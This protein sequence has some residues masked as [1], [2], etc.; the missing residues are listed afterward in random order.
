M[1]T[2]FYTGLL[3]ALA[4]MATSLSANASTEV[5]TIR[6]EDHVFT[7]KKDLLMDKSEF[8]LTAFQR[9]FK[10]NRQTHHLETSLTGS[11]KRSLAQ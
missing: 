10:V 5:V 1:C 3:H 4:D 6:V 7:V 2:I 8:F 9:G 11:R